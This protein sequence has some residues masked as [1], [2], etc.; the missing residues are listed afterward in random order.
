M[1]ITMESSSAYCIDQ[2]FKIKY[3]DFKMLQVAK[4]I[5]DF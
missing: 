4:I 2:N 5:T 1:E 3:R